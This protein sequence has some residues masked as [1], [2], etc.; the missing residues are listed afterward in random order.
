SHDLVAYQKM[1]SKQV[2]TDSTLSLSP[3][4]PQNSKCPPTCS[5]PKIY[6]IV[7]SKK[8]TLVL[9]W[10]AIIHFFYILYLVNP[11]D[12]KYTIAGALF[13]FL[14][15]LYPLS[16]WIADAFLTRFWTMFIG[17]L[18]VIV[19][20]FVTTLLRFYTSASVQLIGLMISASGQALF[21][22]NAIQFGLDQ[23]QTHST[24]NYRY[25]VYW[26]YW[27]MELGHF[28]YGTF[29]CIGR[30]YADNEATHDIT[31]AIFS[32]IQISLLIL[33]TIQMLCWRRKF[34]NHQ[35]G[36]HPFKL[37][38]QVLN[39]SR[40]HRRSAHPISAFQY[41][42]NE[43]PSCLDRSKYKYGGPFTTEQVEDVKVFFY[44]LLLLVP[45][46]AIYFV[47]ELHT[48][49]YQ[50]I[51]DE[52]LKD[53]LPYGK[54]LLVEVPSWIRSALAFF[55]IPVYIFLISRV[56]NRFAYHTSLLWRLGIALCLTFAGVLTLFGLQLDITLHK[57]SN[58]TEFVSETCNSTNI[59][60]YN[61][62]LVPEVL[63]G[64]SYVIIFSST[65]EFV[66]AQSPYS[67]KG[68]L[69]GIWFSFQ[70]IDSVILALQRFFELDCYFGYYIAKGILM[71]GLM[72][73]FL[74]SARVYRYRRR[75]DKD[76]R[77]I[78]EEYY[79]TKGLEDSEDNDYNNS[80][81]SVNRYLDYT[82][83]NY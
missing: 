32:S 35:T 34:Y 47:D 21:E 11:S 22:V 76:T 50:F 13:G 74:F 69:I 4:S 58:I 60:N 53:R 72:I 75:Q 46:S 49:A 79:N 23:L 67:T 57:M 5:M 81:N 43:V 42:D 9:I 39:Y 55:L 36:S 19:G 64:L 3:S 17:Q 48:L 14:L 24:D 7:E 10:S 63:N 38:I 25:Y 61:W 51:S 66:C 27:T 52:E 62:L 80:N 20:S 12:E 82:A 78:I 73:L 40:K 2:K 59:I 77:T 54:C 30:G 45:L 29:V 6:G 68:F 15:I 18:L 83:L 28:L 70:G 37:I 71:M 33:M 31:G 56:T 44:I 26:Y 65:L 1:A 8:A 41:T 16:G